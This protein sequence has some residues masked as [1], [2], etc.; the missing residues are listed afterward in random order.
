MWKRLLATSFILI[1]TSSLL[2]VPAIAATD[3]YP[4]STLSVPVVIDEGSYCKLL[5]DSN[6]TVYL[7]YLQDHHRDTFPA[8]FVEA[9]RDRLYVSLEDLF[10]EGVLSEHADVQFRPRRKVSARY[11]KLLK[12]HRSLAVGDSITVIP[13]KIDLLN[14]YLELTPV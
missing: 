3:V 9:T 7:L 11:S 5:V 1:L 10:I 14:R 13:G 2:A 12:D 6:N 8:R 4:D